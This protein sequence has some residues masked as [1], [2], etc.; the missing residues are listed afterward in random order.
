MAGSTVTIALDDAELQRA[1]AALSERLQQPAPA[2]RDVGEYLLRSTDEH[3]RQERAPD[4]TPWPP[5]SDV[6]LLRRLQARSA[7]LSKRRTATGGRTLT[8]KGAKVLGAAKILR[9]SGD[10]QDTIRYQLVDGGRALAVGTDRVYGAMQ[11]FGGTR[12]QWPHLWGDIPA[13]PFLGLDAD[14]RAEI[15][16]IWQRHLLA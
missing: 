14:D 7:T 8:Q 5:L 10:L 3:F 11:Q 13:R 2:L 16:A 9:D 6:T 15:L 4:G 1:L 12:A